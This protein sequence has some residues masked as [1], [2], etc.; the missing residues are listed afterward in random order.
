MPLGPL[1]DVDEPPRAVRAPRQPLPLS[2]LP[3]SG[4]T[5]FTPDV[6]G[7][8][9]MIAVG[10][11]FMIVSQH[12]GFVFLDRNGVPLATRNG[13]DAKH[14]LSDIFGDFI[15]RGSATD[16]NRWVGF[17]TPC[18]STTYPQTR[19]GKR[20]CIGEFYDLR[21]YYDAG[22][23]RFILL[24]HAR[25]ALWTDIWAD[26]K[27]YQTELGTCGLYE[28]LGGAEALPVPDQAH[29]SLTRRHAVFAISKSSDPRDGFHTYAVIENNVQDW[30]WGAVNPW[31]NTFVIGH[32]GVEMT[33]G[34][35]AMVLR[36]SDLRAGAPQP[37]YFKLYAKDVGGQ[38][39]PAPLVH[40]GATKEQGLTLLAASRQRSGGDVLDVYGFAAPTGQGGKPAIH[41]RIHVLDDGIDLP[42]WMARTVYRAGYLFMAWEVDDPSDSTTTFRVRTLRH[43]F[44]G[45]GPMTNTSPGSSQR[46]SWIGK[47][48]P[49]AFD[50]DDVKPAI[51]VNARGDAIVAFSRA[52][53]EQLLFVIW[54]AESAAPSPEVVVRARPQPD[55]RVPLK[56]D[57]AWAVVDPV[58]DLTFWFAHLAKKL[59]GS[60]ETVVVRVAR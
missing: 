27:R 45:F 48:T 56:I 23:D 37:A 32:K 47:A 57:Y 12:A 58:D 17:E 55:F 46:A 18:D 35:A 49:A 7:V 54:P 26:N 16:L 43:R 50:V 60:R 53:G 38:V 9:P 25:N 15:E 39:N 44:L 41:H 19:T 3:P 28:P 42:S 52:G 36:L 4:V 11:Q 31:G 59:D 24:A 6:S 21:T 29:C 2:P 13:V 33:H 14:G 20:Y 1:G 34:M 40:H 51:A 22:A 10:R 30:P 5:V 8:D